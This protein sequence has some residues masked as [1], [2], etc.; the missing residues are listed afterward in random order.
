MLTLEVAASIAASIKK[1]QRSRLGS[2]ADLRNT[3]AM[4]LGKNDA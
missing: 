3:G 2:Y 4:A 1:I